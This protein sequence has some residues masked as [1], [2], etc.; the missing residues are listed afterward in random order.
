MGRNKENENEV[1]EIVVKVFFFIFSS[2]NHFE[3][4][5]RNQEVEGYN[6]YGVLGTF[7]FYD[8]S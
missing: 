3:L 4:T 2:C 1:W 5:A 6:P 7:S 8:L